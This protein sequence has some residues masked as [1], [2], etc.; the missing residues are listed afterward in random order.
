[1]TQILGRTE[2]DSSRLNHA[3]QDGVQ[4]KT[5][6]LFISGIFHLIFFTVI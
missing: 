3:M 6:E 1:M 2:L 5:Y 4:L